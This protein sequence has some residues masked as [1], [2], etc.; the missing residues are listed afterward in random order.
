[1]TKGED[2]RRSALAAA[3]ELASTEGLAGVTIGRL[4]DH[5]G[6]SKSGLFAHFQSK[7]GLDIEILRTAIERFTV[8][9]IVPA[10]K[11][12]RG[13]PRVVTLFERWLAWPQ[14]FSGGCIFVAA[15]VELDDRPGPVREVLVTSQRDWVDTLAQA[16]R[17]AIEVG[18]FR[19]DLD[20]QQLAH[21]LYSLGL[22]H[23][24]ASRLLAP[25]DGDVRTHTAFE[26]ILRDARNP[27]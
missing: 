14:Q 18:H 23:H 6:M 13:E 8:G 17:I 3:L 10:L 11:A 12:K 22:G 20:A 24:M 1:M 27:S 16:G 15:G 5:V 21:E 4:A 25:A 19:P 2:T 9:V 7:E 26:R